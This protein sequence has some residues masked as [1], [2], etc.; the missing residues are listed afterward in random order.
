VKWLRIVAMAVPFF[1]LALLVVSV[2]FGGSP[3]LTLVGAMLVVAGMAQY[4]AMHIWRGLRPDSGI[5][6]DEIVPIE[7]ERT[8]G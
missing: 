3:L 4:A 2:A 5:P 1:G 6:S 8:H 7:T